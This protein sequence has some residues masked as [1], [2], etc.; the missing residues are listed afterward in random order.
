VSHHA[1]K[2]IKDNFTLVSVLALMSDDPCH[3]HLPLAFGDR[4]DTIVQ[5]FDKLGDL[6]GMDRWP[7]KSMPMVILMQKRALRIQP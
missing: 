6:L 3:S 7:R 5:T 4:H 2:T 1:A